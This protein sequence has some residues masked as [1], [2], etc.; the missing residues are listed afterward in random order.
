MGEFL[1]IFKINFRKGTSLIIKIKKIKKNKIYQKLIK[2][3]LL[4]NLFLIT[5]LNK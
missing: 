1:M 4:Q 2:N 3:F 5:I